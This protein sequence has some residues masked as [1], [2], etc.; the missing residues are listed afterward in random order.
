MTD[1]RPVQPR[2]ADDSARA[3]IRSSLRE[4]LL[5]EAAA[6]TGKT[7]SLVE[8]MVSLVAEGIPADRIAA[9]TFTIKAA[10]QLDERF[11]SA[12]ELAARQDPDAERR[13]RFEKALENLDACFIGTI[14]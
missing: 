4:T 10:A 5:V 14:H 12:L 11:Q 7:T 9:V 6:G 13:A 1:K 8:R 2:L 3:E